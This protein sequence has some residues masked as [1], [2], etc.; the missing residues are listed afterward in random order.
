MSSLYLGVIGGYEFLWLQ[1]LAMICGVIMLMAI[2]HVTLSISDQGKRPF[3]VVKEHIS[4]VLAWGWLVATIVANIVFCSSQFALA[5]DTIQTNLGFPINSYLITLGLFVIAFGMTYLSKTREQ[6]SR[7]INNVLKILVSLIVLSFI[8]LA[9]LLLNNGSIDM[10]DILKGLVPDLTK[11]TSPVSTLEPYISSAGADSAYWVEH[12]VNNQRDVI[13]G[14]FGTAVGINMTFL[15]PYTLLSKGWSAKEKD[16]SRYDMGFGLLIPFILATSCL[17]IVSSSQ[18]HGLVDSPVNEQ[19]YN[20]ILDKKLS[21][22]HH[23][24]GALA[25]DAKEQL[26]MEAPSYDKQM[27]TIMAKRN[28]V[29]LS[30][31]LEPILGRWATIIF[32]LGVLAM[33]LSTML[34]HMM[35]NG[36]ALGEA[37]GRPFDKKPYLIGSAI[38]ALLGI[39]SPVLWSGSIKTALV[40]PASVIATIFLPIAYIAFM[41]LMN[42]KKVFGSDRPGGDQ[43]WLVNVLMLISTGVALFASLWAI[44]A[45]IQSPKFYEK[46][47]AIVGLIVFVITIAIGLRGF[48]KKEK[49]HA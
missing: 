42:S 4:P 41:M 18:F 11:V 28:T 6:W 20:L 13:I 15:L 12:V 14:A 21:R 2:A 16:L 46:S 39:I 5:T 25:D 45:K 36:Y 26:R 8:V 29:D 40:I 33:A 27:S 7:L 17:V 24:Y 31:T 49:Q 47:L 22:D 23:H 10:V 3:G 43:H 19:A 34:V 9:I 48:I 38:P 44:Y 1:P 37:I 30:A 35:M 32:G